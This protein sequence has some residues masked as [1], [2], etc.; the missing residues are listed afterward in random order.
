VQAWYIHLCTAIQQAKA[1]LLK[2]GAVCHE[3]LKILLSVTLVATV[4]IVHL[5]SKHDALLLNCIP[6]FQT[7]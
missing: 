7:E 5:A 1:L 4:N 6:H 3:T 2:L